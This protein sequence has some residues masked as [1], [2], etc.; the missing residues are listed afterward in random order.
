[1]NA[2]P[3]KSVV[4]EFLAISVEYNFKKL[5]LEVSVILFSVYFEQDL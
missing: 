4:G 3:I 1:M 2:R 5:Q